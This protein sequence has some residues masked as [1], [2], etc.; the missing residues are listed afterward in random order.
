MNVQTR[1][2]T[3]FEEPLPCRR[4]HPSTSSHRHPYLMISL[5]LLVTHKSKSFL[6]SSSRRSLC[7]RGSDGGG[8]P[9]SDVF[10]VNPNLVP[11]RPPIPAMP[12][13]MF[14]RMAHSQ[15]EL[16]AFSLTAPGDS[17]ESKVESMALYLPQENVLNGQLE[18]TPV[19]LYPDPNTERVFIA[20]DAASGQAPTLPRTLTKL[21][22]FAHAT[23]LLPG[24]PM[25]SSDSDNP[26]IGVVEEVMCDARNR[27]KPA[28]LSVPLLSGSQTV[29]VLLVSP[30]LGSD[31]NQGNVW[32]DL[33]REQVSRAA[34]SLSMALSMDSE[35]NVLKEQNNAFREGLSDSLHQ[36]KSPLQ[37]LRT[38]GKLLQRQLAS[39]TELRSGTPALLELTER[40]MVQSERVI[41]LMVPMDTLVEN[42]EQSTR[43]ALQPAKVEPP[44]SLVVRSKPF[45][46]LPWEKETLDFAREN[47]TSNEHFN[48]TKYREFSQK[49]L[50]REAARQKPRH[51]PLRSVPRS[52]T[53]GVVGELE[54]E[55]TFVADVLEPIT[56]AF[57]ALAP[58]RGIQFEVIQDSSELPGVMAAPKAL[59]EAISNI[60]DNAFKYVLLP[61]DGSPFSKNPAPHVRLRMMSTRGSESGVIIVVEDN[62]P[63][64]REDDYEAIFQ[65][66][67]R[68]EKTSDLPGS[69]IGLDISRTLVEGMGGSLEVAHSEEFKNALNG[70]IIKCTLL[71]RRATK[72]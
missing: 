59:Q 48:D 13:D 10:D 40:L 36:V 6:F 26:G 22:G 45:Q 28:A 12:S 42:L 37:A 21:P 53:T 30:S 38:Y 43:L 54:V 20:S 18:F 7:L 3:R 60:L 50:T 66:G 69:G 2:M 68:A 64:I 47:S 49:R 58:E 55:M 9:L 62:G 27:N 63:G 56:S 33:D 57:F 4:K 16:L 46:L 32:T 23:T 5:L 24:Y 51:I 41:D 19:V 17:S 31:P 71:R 29:G 67:F 65:R 44:K 52:S 34:Q 1:K 72:H 35:R 61:K 14:R 39:T 70:A 11:E 8:E 25:M 15:L